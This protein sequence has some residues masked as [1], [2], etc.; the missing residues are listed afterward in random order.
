MLIGLH[1]KIDSKTAAKIHTATAI[2][3]PVT[4]AQFFSAICKGIFEYLLV[5]KTDHKG[6]F[7]SVLTYFDTVKTNN[8]DMLHLHCLV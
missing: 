2:I 7:G 4:V 5:V 6:L 3:N 8:Q 1:Y